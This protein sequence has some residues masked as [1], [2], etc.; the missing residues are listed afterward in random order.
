MLFGRRLSLVSEE[1]EVVNVEV[2]GAQLEK[3]EAWARIFRCVGGCSNDV[4][5]LHYY[6]GGKSTPYFTVGMSILPASVGMRLIFPM[7]GYATWHSYR[8]CID[9]SAWPEHPPLPGDGHI[10]LDTDPS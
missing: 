2:N 5:T 3:S 9:A 7:L 10:S 1:D 8:E 6:S 4:P